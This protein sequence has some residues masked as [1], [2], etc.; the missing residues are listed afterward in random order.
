MQLLSEKFGKMGFHMK[1]L[2]NGLDFGEVLENEN[3][4]SI[5]R[6]TTFSEDTNDPI[7]IIGSLEL[8]VES[9]HDSLLKNRFL[10][11]TKT[12]TVRFEDFSTYTRSKTIQIWTSDLFVIKRTA[13]QLLSEFIGGRKLRLVGIGVTKLRERD[14]KQTLITDF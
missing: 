4:K 1:Q 3:I 6:H 7:R 13:I 2:A 10:F 5:S 14:K 11:K 9:V 12:L 8:L